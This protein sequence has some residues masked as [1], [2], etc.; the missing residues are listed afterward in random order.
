MATGVDGVW[1]PGTA[2][3]LV[4][5][6]FDKVVDA[7]KELGTKTK[8]AIEE[9]HVGDR[10]KAAGSSIAAGGKLAGTYLVDRTKS[11]ASAVVAKGKE[12]RVILSGYQTHIG[13][14][15]TEANRGLREGETVQGR[16]GHLGRTIPV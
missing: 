12:L 10:M 2:M 13:T 9:V 11:A 14:P 6:G 4:R 15:A 3:K 7:A 8:G 1:L 16:R 5:E